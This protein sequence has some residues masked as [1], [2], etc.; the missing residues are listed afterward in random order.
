[1]SRRALALIGIAFA[2]VGYLHAGKQ[3]VPNAIAP[4]VS[5]QRAVLSRYCITCHNEKLKTAGLILDKMDVQKV[6]EAAPSWE[7]VI[8]KL[9]TG[10]MPPAG[11]P[12]P[13]KAAYDAL[14]TYLESELDRAAAD[15]PNPGRPAIHRLNRSEYSNAVRD[16]LAIDADAVDI[17]SLLPVDDS[18]YGFDNI[19]D[20]LSLSPVLLERYIA[21]ARKISRLAVGDPAVRSD[22]QTYE[23]SRF[24]S[25]RD[26]ANE[27]LPFGSRGGT[28]IRHFFPLDGEYAIKIDLKRDWINALNPIAGLAEPHQ[29][30]IRLDGASVKIFTIGGKGK[31]PVRPGGSNYV[32]D[33]GQT[34]A[35]ERPADTDLEVR[36]PMKAGSHFIGVTFSGGVDP[37]APEEVLRP[38][39]ASQQIDDEP[40]VGSITIKGPFNVRGPGDT[41]SRR[42]IFVCHP[43]T[44]QDEEPC[45][46]KIV[47]TIVRRAYRGEASNEDLATVLGFFRTG[48][49]QEGFERGIEI[50][51][52]RILISPQFLFRI[53]RDPANV[54]PGASYRVSDLELASRLSFFLWSSIPDDE[55]L[56]VAA[57]GKLRDTA[58]LEQQVRRMLED[59]RSKALVSNFAGQWLYLRNVRTAEPDLKEFPDFD[60]DLR[61]AL[62]QETGLFFE[63]MLREDRSVLDLLNADYTFLNERLARHYAIPNIYGSHFRRVTMKDENRRGLLGQGSILMVTSYANRTSP[64]LRGKWILENMLGAPPPPPPPN[65]PSLMDRGDDGK[66]LSV[67]QQMEQHRA[68]PQCAS[69]HAQMDPLGFALENF[70]ATGKWRTVSG[71]NATPVDASG[72]LPDGTKFDGPAQ[73]RQLL[74]SRSQQFLTVVTEKFLTYALGRGLEYYDEP[75]VRKI[76]RTAAP[77][78]RW[79]SLILNIVKSDPFQ[80]RRSPDL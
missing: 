40:G 57:R 75:S 20:V 3:D 26:R 23:V 14:A 34:T 18:G 37:L 28:S 47:S 59:S 9:R 35:N 70:D 73:L 12:R 64:T 11:M 8:R 15:K 67:R 43:A 50:A 1:M 4:T 29:M 19:G 51:L 80:M 48:R 53:E 24:L 56:D 60:D 7:T 54:Q 58:V 52:Q 68:N 74:L 25:Q 38:P 13:D 41:A 22:V 31:Q 72:A 77:D 16:L 63:S 69:C 61:A 78:Y 79:S 17:P 62:E 32:L 71:A 66:I 36:L 65:V 33:A 21:A 5:S 39:L 46:K 76:M 27:D 49:S 55:L 10:A 45:A 42:K 6:T 44:V 30:D 2:G